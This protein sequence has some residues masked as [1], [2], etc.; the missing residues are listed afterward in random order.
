LKDTIYEP[1]EVPK[2]VV[3]P[4][5]GLCLQ[6]LANGIIDLGISDSGKAHVGKDTLTAAHVI[7]KAGTV[8]KE[9]M[10]RILAYLDDNSWNGCRFVERALPP[11]VKKK[12]KVRIIIY[13]L[14]SQCR[15]F[16]IEA[17]IPLVPQSLLAFMSDET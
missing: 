7:V 6:L 2:G 5:H 16:L 14:L 12:R 3:G 8:Q 17:H 15:L 4:I 1:D 11:K 13:S 10:P 9:G